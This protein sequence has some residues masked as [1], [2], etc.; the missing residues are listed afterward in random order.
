M[1]IIDTTLNGKW[2]QTL[3]NMNYQFYGKFDKFTGKWLLITKK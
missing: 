2:V 3:N 1:T